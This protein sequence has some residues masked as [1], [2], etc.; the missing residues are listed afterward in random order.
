MHVVDP[1]HLCLTI[2]PRP[3]HSVSIGDGPW[4]GAPHITPRCV[5][6]NLLS[7]VLCLTSANVS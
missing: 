7:L 6:E 5:K 4:Q 1:A 2:L 3:A